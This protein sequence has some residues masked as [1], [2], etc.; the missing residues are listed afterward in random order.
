[1]AKELIMQLLIKAS[2]QMLNWTF[3]KNSILQD[4]FEISTIKKKKIKLKNKV[5]YL[6]CIQQVTPCA[7]NN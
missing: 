2:L 6:G 4:G 5:L 3:N 7:H 1:M